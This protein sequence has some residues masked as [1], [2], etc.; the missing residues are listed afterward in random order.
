MSNRCTCGRE[1]TVAYHTLASTYKEKTI[2][3]FNVPIDSCHYCDLHYGIA[4]PTDE[5][6]ARMEQRL[7]DAY[8]K[9]LIEI[10]YEED[11]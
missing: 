1:A 6:E 8:S 2:A 3:V 7:V 9:G 10:D 5:V 4:R 11:N